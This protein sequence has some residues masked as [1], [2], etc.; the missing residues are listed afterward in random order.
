MR[1]AIRAPFLWRYDM[2]PNTTARDEELHTTPD[3]ELR[4]VAFAYRQ[5]DAEPVQALSGVS[6]L[7]PRGSYS[8]LLGRNGSGKSTMAK[9]INVLELPTTGMVLVQGKETS[10][11]AFFWDIRRSCGMVFQNPDNQIVGTIVEEDVAFGPENLGV[12]TQEIRRRVDEALKR[13]GMA[14]FS[15]RQPSQLSGGQKQKVA[16]AGILAMHPQILLLDESTSMLDPISRDDFLSV[17]E[18]LVRETNMTLLHITHDMS[19]ACRAEQVFV[20]DQGH[21]SMSGTPGEVFSQVDKIQALGLEVPVF[22]DI[23]YEMAKKLSVSLTKEN[24]SS[25]K[26][27]IEAAHLMCAAV[28]AV[29][30]EVKTVLYNAQK[31]ELLSRDVLQISHLSYSYD[32]DGDEVL[33]DISFSVR[34]GEIFA[35]IGH[36]GSGKTTL[37]SHINGLIRPQHG[38]VLVFP[39]GGQT[40]LST[41]TNKDVKRIRQSVGLLFQYPEYQL[42][43]ETVE[44]DIAFGPKKMGLSTEEIDKRIEESLELVGLD[45]SFRKRSPFEL[46]GGQ[47]RRVAFAGVLAMDPEI[48]VLDEPAAG[49]DPVGRKEIFHYAEVLKS[50]GKTVIIVSHNMDEAARYADRILV[51]KH[52]RMCALDQPHT[53]FSDSGKLAEIG[54]AAPETLAFL[55][56]MKL[57]YEDIQARYFRPKE[58][59][60]ELIR[61]AARKNSLV[62]GDHSPQGGTFI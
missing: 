54:I 4:D 47:K 3:V 46:S 34:K 41:K 37:I 12:P 16:I 17:V 33:S 59:A 9:L 45:A 36:S 24:L 55:S 51:L 58:A 27:A 20:L 42:F 52:G 48:L 29:P 30:E 35:I 31:K 22:A 28:Q 39:D 5:P 26:A 2:N 40:S 15:L 60:C 1:I 23:V 57:D 13:V 43:E 25:R 49:L 7:L 18:D 61:A 32:K 53:L 44:K 50:K 6:L 10:N 8:V 21:L 19:E 56:E 62:S 38:E 14:D 11:E